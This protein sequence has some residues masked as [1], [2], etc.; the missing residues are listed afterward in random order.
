M[1]KK[2]TTFNL[3]LHGLSELVCFLSESPNFFVAV[4]FHQVKF[5]DCATPPKNRD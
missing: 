1:L 2:L 5:I 4:P 3:D